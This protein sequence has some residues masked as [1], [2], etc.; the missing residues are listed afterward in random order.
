VSEFNGI[1]AESFAFM[2]NLKANNNRLWFHKHRQ[3]W[4]FARDELKSLCRKLSPFINDLDPELETEPKTGRTLGRI[5]RDIR[6]S[7][8]KRPYRESV[9]LLFFNRSYGRTKAPGLAVG[10]TPIDSYIGTWLG[11]TM[12]DWRQRLI[13]NIAAHREAFQQ[14]LEQNDNFSDLSLRSES[15]KK[16]QIKDLPPLAD[17]WAQRKY[18]YM[19]LLLPAGKVVSL[20]AGLME[21]IE[22]TFIRLYPL[23]L[24]ATSQELAADLERFRRKFEH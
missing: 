22:E 5:N 15:Y 3:E 20:G 24:F 4:E 13:A 8:S 16:T 2:L 17:Q 18:Y 7:A 23:Y 11:A 12:K 6:F 10:I 9:D 1:S 19:A 14:Y 21:I